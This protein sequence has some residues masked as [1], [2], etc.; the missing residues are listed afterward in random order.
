M[1]VIVHTSIHTNFHSIVI[2]FFFFFLV[3]IS[4]TLISVSFPSDF[5]SV[6]LA[7]QILSDSFFIYKL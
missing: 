3:K 5:S 2:I 4:E 6:I 1:V 7:G